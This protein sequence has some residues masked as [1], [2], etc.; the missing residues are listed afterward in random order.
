MK[1]YICGSSMVS[2]TTDLP[3]KIGKKSILIIKELPVIECPNCKEYLIED[4]VM[5]RL[6]VMINRMDEKTELEIVAYP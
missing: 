1:C 5:E 3:F 6:E 4:A 2:D